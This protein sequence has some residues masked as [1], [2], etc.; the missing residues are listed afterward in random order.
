MA[1][2]F[3]NKWPGKVTNLTEEQW[4]IFINA[5]ETSVKDGRIIEA[6]SFDFDKI[7]SNPQQTVVRRGADFLLKPKVSLSFESAV[8]YFEKK[9]KLVNLFTFIFIFYCFLFF[10][11]N[12][13]FNLKTFEQA[14]YGGSK[15]EYCLQ[16][17]A[18]KVD[19]FSTKNPASIIKDQP[20]I[21]QVNH[22]ITSMHV[23]ASNLYGCNPSGDGIKIWIILPGTE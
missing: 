17:W 8:E 10:N 3:A 20:D 15:I 21:I 14:I 6:Y 19:L 22:F 1:E 16:G 5:A 12:F 2:Q 7:V 13:I 9:T 18:K 23:D 11:L 4:S